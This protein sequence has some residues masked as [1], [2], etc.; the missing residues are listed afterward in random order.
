MKPGEAKELGTGRVAF[1]ARKDAIKAKIEAGRTSMSV[2]REYQKEVDISYS[3]FARYIAKFIRSK[4]NEPKLPE[5]GK[6]QKPE[7]DDDR[8]RF[9]P[10]TPKLDDLV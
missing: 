3:Q 10:S 9:K 5:E 6:N 7:P 2:Y 4:P 8:R 1:L